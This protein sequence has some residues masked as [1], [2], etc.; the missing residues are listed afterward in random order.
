M[1]QRLFPLRLLRTGALVSLAII[2]GMSIVPGGSRPT[3]EVGGLLFGALGVIEHVAGYAVCG[4]FFALGF[5]QWRASM[6]FVGLAA[7]ACGLEVAQMFVAERT[8]K[9]SDAILSAAGVALGIY[10]AI[11]LK[12]YWSK[13][14]AG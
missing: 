8:P 2:I 11:W 3:V 5:A 6:I 1:I 13:H 14:S 9:V 7:L 4:C 10:L 12:P